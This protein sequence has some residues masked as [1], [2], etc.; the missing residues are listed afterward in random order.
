[1]AIPTSR[2][3]SY[4]A[5]TQETTDRMEAQGHQGHR[6]G[7]AHRRA[8]CGQVTGRVWRRRDQ[9]RAGRHRRPAAQ[10]R[11]LKV[12]GVVPKLSATPGRIVRPAPQ[13]GEH[14]EEVVS[15]DGWPVQKET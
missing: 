5:C 8:V 4:S 1:M 13:L 14:T 10:W 7:T 3:R 9:G 2:R 11:L 15:A 12:P 6:V